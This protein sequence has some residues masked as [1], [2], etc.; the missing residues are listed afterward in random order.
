MNEVFI[1]TPVEVTLEMIG[2]VLRRRWS[3]DEDLAQPSVDLGPSRWAYVA[4][5]DD[6]DRE[7]P[8]F[9]TPD[10]RDLLRRRI[11]DYRLFSVRYA[12]P[13]LGLASIFQ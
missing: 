11:G 2:D 10:E 7:D 6:E 12:S 5:V 4:E 1:A 9:L 8:L 3:L 13:V